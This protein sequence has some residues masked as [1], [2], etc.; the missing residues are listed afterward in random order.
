MKAH[1][2]LAVG[3]ALAMAALQAAATTLPPSQTENGITFVNGG[4][5]H[6][7]AAA[8]KTEARHYPL[9][10][11]FSAAKDHE[12][13]ADVKLTIRSK[14]GREVLRTSAGPI[15]LLNVPAGSYA[16]TAE[17]KGTTLHRSVHVKSQGGTE[18]DFH[19]PQA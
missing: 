15:T 3:A 5:G 19:W 18:V 2:T 14:S 13:V 16:I 6:D 12:F 1:I 17:L 9:S 4:V 8:M 11:T 10:I 7:E